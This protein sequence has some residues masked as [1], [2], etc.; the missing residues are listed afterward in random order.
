MPGSRWIAIHLPG[1]R[2]AFTLIE[3][4]VTVGIIS[5]LLGLSAYT[6]TRVRESNTLAQA[7][8]AVLTYAK[9]A[10]SYAI[11]NHV[12]TMMV[13]NPFNGRFE[14][15]YL[16]PPSGGGPFD[17]LSSGTLPPFTDGYAFAPVLDSGARLPVD[18][19]G[20]PL[21]TV[22]PIDFDDNDRRPYLIHNDPNLDNLTWSAFCFDKSGKLVIR[23]RRIATRTYTQRDGTLRGVNDRNRLIDETPDLSVFFLG[24]MVMGGVNGDTPITSTV[25][26]VISEAPKMRQA[27]GPN[28][29]THELVN[30]W[31]M[32]TRPG[33]RYSD[34]AST[35][36]LN[37]FSGAELVGA[38]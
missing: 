31:L 10:R 21:A 2:R 3:T 17:P 6:F 26:F 11:A 38:Y 14:I 15:W 37:R 32:R 4:I 23:T 20:Q 16:N 36:V 34:F 35:V 9:I 33:G 8:N 18:G 22:N 5:L 24:P 30:D 1:G 27:L 29:L 19:R 25:G 28:P 7:R 13:V 12:E